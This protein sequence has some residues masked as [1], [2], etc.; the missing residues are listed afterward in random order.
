MICSNDVHFIEEAHAEAHHRLICLNTGRD[1]DDMSG[2]AYTKQE[3]LKTQEEMNAVFSDVP[4]ALGNT[5]E[6]ADKGGIFFHRPFG[7]YARPSLCRMDLLMEM[8][9]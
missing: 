5:L 2:M 1:L 8:I 6:I 4:E 7:H 3:W 9:T